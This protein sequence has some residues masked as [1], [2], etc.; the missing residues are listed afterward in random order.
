MQDARLVW[1]REMF[2]GMPPG[3]SVDNHRIALPWANRSNLNER[4][5]RL[6]DLADGS[7]IKIPKNPQMWGITVALSPDGKML[8]SLK[9]SNGRQSPKVMALWDIHKGTLSK[10]LD[11]PKESPLK[12]IS[13]VAF[14]PDGRFLTVTARAG[15][16]EGMHKYEFVVW[17]IETGATHTVS[18]FGFMPTLSISYSADGKSLVYQSGKKTISLLQLDSDEKPIEMELPLKIMGFQIALSPDG[19]TL[20]TVPKQ[21]S[22]FQ[23]LSIIA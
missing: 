12:Q 16:F 18:G 15:P 3:V 11:W 14:S 4:G 2:P 8:A 10:T 20:G 1:N 5:V 23:D 7:D 6:I 19:E 21:N 9:S 17:N 13:H 22:Y